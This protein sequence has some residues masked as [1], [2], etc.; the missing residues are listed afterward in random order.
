MAWEFASISSDGLLVGPHPRGA[1]TFPRVLG[2]Y[3]RE[4]RLLSLEEAVRKMTSLPAA[5]V[6]ITDR[7]TIEPGKA[8]DL[9][10]FDPATVIDRATTDDPNALSV[11]VERVWVNGVLVWD[12]TRPTGNYPGRFI[13]RNVDGSAASRSEPPSP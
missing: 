1:G 2:R 11:G 4:R 10:L 8:A 3:V 7:G 5:S 13:R 6:G 12:G 9:V